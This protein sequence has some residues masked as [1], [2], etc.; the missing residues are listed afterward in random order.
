M[1][2]NDML[3]LAF[4]KD[5]PKV[6]EYLAQMTQAKLDAE[7]A[8][9]AAQAEQG[10]A[11]EILRQD[12]A[13]RARAAEILDQARAA[14]ALADDKEKACAGVQEAQQSEKIEF[15]KVRSSVTN[16]LTQREVAV[17]ARESAMDRREGDM[18][19]REHQVSVREKTAKELHDSLNRKHERLRMALSDNEMEAAQ[20]PSAT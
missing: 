2:S 13:E 19:K 9:K 6:K 10:K 20:E 3:F 14:Q 18:V 17:M 5:E 16:N 11:Q 12:Q 7:M 8:Q 4:A 1:D 15:E